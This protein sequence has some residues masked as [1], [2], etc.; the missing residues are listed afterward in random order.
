MEERKCREGWGAEDFVSMLRDNGFPQA[1][2]WRL[3][4]RPADIRYN[5]PRTGSR[6]GG[7]ATKTWR[8]SR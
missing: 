7:A 4:L 2:L 5:G 1:E 3:P 8:G 6:L